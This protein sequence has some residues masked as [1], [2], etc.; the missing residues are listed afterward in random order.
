M[1]WGWEREH[2]LARPWS[3]SSVAIHLPVSGRDV[4]APLLEYFIS[5]GKLTPTSNLAGVSAP[6]GVS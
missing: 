1:R 6:S 5:S 2:R 3:L 4:F